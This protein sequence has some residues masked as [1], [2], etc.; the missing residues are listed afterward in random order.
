MRSV[1]LVVWFLGA[2]A[3]TTEELTF[4]T[5][6]GAAD[7]VTPKSDVKTVALDGSKDS[8]QSEVKIDAV[9]PSGDSITDPGPVIAPSD[10]FG[11]ETAVDS[12]NA[13]EVSFDGQDVVFPTGCR[14]IDHP[15][16]GKS[17]LLLPCQRTQEECDK[18]DNDGDGITDPHCNSIACWSDSDCTLNG[19]IPDA[20]CDF[21]ATPPA[22]LHIDGWPKETSAGPGFK[23]SGVACPPG[24]KCV[25]GDCV[26]PGVGL[27][28]APCSGGADCPIN[29]GCNTNDDGSGGECQ[30]A[31]EN[32]ACPAGTTCLVEQITVQKKPFVTSECLALSA[33]A[34]GPGGCAQPLSACFDGKNACP[35]LQ[36]CFWDTCE[37]SDT[38]GC[39]RSCLATPAGATEAALK[40]CLD[41][42]C[43]K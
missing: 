27:P 15:W 36:Q 28:G 21:N 18:K 3:C 32:V 11:P 16:D 13:W 26:Q 39:I 6:V 1:V 35:G 30:Q 40:T 5:N 9:A 43:P 20:R 34:Q 41:A 42:A 7:S 24:L 22:C 17:P 33:C 29:S 37:S 25:G 14:P 38:I 2:S 8:A 12:S 4:V 23:C 31:C 10:G 19:L